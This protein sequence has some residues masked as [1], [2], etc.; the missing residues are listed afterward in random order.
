M[1]ALPAVAVIPVVDPAPIRA[2]FLLFPTSGL[3]HRF[4]TPLTLNRVPNIRVPADIGLDG[5][6][7]QPE[8]L[9]DR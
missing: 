5:I 9:R 6:D 4:R 7:R 3:Q 8:L 1:L 2:E